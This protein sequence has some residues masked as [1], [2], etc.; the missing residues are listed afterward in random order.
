MKYYPQNTVAHYTTKLPQPLDL[1]G[2][3]EVGLAEIIYPH[4]WLPRQ[5]KSKDHWVE[6]R[7]P[8]K[9]P[10]RC[11]LTFGL[12]KNTE[13]M[14][15]DLNKQLEAGFTADIMREHGIT[16]EKL[17]FK[18]H[19]YLHISQYIHIKVE[20]IDYSTHLIISKS[21][22]GLLG[23][24]SS[25]KETRI[26]GMRL[27]NG[28]YDVSADEIFDKFA[29]LR[30]M[31]IYCDVAAHTCVG[32]TQAPLLRTC[33]TEGEYGDTVQKS[34]V[35]THYIPVQKRHFDTIE[36]SINTEDG[37]PMPFE[38]GKSMV[39]LHFRRAYNLPSI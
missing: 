36:I 27:R 35:D 23:F 28:N 39:K 32:D 15:T 1:D 26:R 10:V 13:D 25:D 38:F 34:F 16:L 24:V 19:F 11:V 2:D 7:L 5:N 33:D 9:R 18:F 21:L 37:K 12:Y 22:W 8:N 31:H 20:D 3:Y 4:S 14:L 17:P 6:V 29:G 30:L